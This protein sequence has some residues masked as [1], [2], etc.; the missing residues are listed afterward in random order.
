MTALGQKQ[1][2]TPVKSMSALPPKADISRRHL[3]VRLA[4]KAEVQHPC[5]IGRST[6]AAVLSA[7]TQKDI[8]REIR[9]A[10]KGG[11]L[12]ARALGC[13]AIGINPLYGDDVRERAAAAPTHDI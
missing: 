1:T 3:R 6:S 5:R 7:L 8:V 10:V 13:T 4:P 9:H 11:G 2:S 12:I